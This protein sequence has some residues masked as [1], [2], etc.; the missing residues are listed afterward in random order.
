MFVNSEWIYY[1]VNFNDYIVKERKN[2]AAIS[3]KTIKAS[4]QLPTNTSNRIH[5]RARVRSRSTLIST[6]Y[7]YSMVRGEETIYICT[8]NLYKL[9][10]SFII[11]PKVAEPGLQLAVL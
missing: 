9:S 8:G 3:S 10:I 5:L 1:G 4:L 11:F 7:I 6:H 2:D